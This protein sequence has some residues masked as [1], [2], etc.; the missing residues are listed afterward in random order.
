MTDIGGAAAAAEVIAGDPHRG[1]PAAEHLDAAERAGVCANCETALEGPY[2]HACGQRAH[3]HSRLRDLFHEAIEGIAH[4]DGRIWRTLPVLA[5]NPGRLSREWR[6]GRRV[7][8]LQPLHLFLFA[9]FLFFTFQS[10]TGQ[11]FINLPSAEDVRSQPAQV[12]VTEAMRDRMVAGRAGTQLTVDETTEAGRKMGQA[13]RH[14]LENAEFYSYKIETLVYKLSFLLAPISMAILAL[15]MVFRR[16]Y[17]FYDH[18]VV[19]LYGVGFGVLAATVYSFVNW[20]LGFV[21]WELTGLVA[22][23]VMLGLAVHAVLHLRGAYGLSW[24]GAVIRGLL[25][26]FLTLVGFG[27]FL[28]GVVA[29]GLFA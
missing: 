26:S 3:L 28:L 10:L 20:L 25:L 13:L 7:R 14:R 11:H 21:G 29:L 12:A 19:S 22:V 24:P 15:L 5:L 8:Y 9:V 2:C 27:L 6:E 16:G 1:N 18:G 4:L 17:S 23:G